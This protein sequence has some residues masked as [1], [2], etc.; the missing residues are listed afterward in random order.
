MGNGDDA[1]NQRECMVLCSYFRGSELLSTSAGL[2]CLLHCLLDVEAEGCIYTLF[3]F[4]LHSDKLAVISP[5][6]SLQWYSR[7]ERQTKRISRCIDSTVCLV[8]DG[9]IIPAFINIILK[10]IFVFVFQQQ[11]IFSAHSFCVH[12]PHHCSPNVYL[13]LFHGTALICFPLRAV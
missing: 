12:F 2:I 3:F 8:E 6:G 5:N 9:G 10:L 1:G 13:L 7:G 11:H 4:C